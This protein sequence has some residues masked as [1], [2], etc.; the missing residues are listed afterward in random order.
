MSGRPSIGL[1]QT[2]PIPTSIPIGAHGTLAKR[3]SRPT[4]SVA[5]DLEQMAA[6]AQARG[7]LAAAAAFLERSAALTVSPS[8][9]ASRALVAATAKYEAAAVD[10]AVALLDMAEGDHLDDFQRAEAEVLRARIA[11][12][13]NRGSDAPPLL[14]AAARRL[15]PLDVA[16]AREAYLDALGAALFSGR[17]STTVDPRQVARAAL[18]APKALEPRPVDMLLDGLAARIAYGPA[19][20]IAQL[21]EALGVYARQDSGPGRGTPL[22][23]AGRPPCRLRLGLLGVGHPYGRTRASRS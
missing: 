23:L 17:L 5:A 8:L 19:T 3:R 16:L 14:L 4:R 13:T 20:G 12:A 21:R 1:S 9:R 10:D 15:E 7:G 6:R 22:A 18:A 11:F 2:R